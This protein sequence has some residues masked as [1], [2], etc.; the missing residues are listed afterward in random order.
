M[1][2][3]ISHFSRWVIVQ[4]PFSISE[5]LVSY[6]IKDDIAKELDE[7]APN[8]WS[9]GAIRQCVYVDLWFEDKKEALNALFYISIRYSE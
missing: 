6:K 1:E 2:D 5:G 4:M 9:M 7:I 3:K 8:G